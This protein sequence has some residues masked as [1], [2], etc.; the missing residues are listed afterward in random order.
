[1]C[2]W[3]IGEMCDMNGGDERV[4]R[5]F[6]FLGRFSIS[7]ALKHGSCGCWR[8]V[9]SV[10]MRGARARGRGGWLGWLW[11]DDR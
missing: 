1:M 5:V 6:F 10:L 4:C 9:S 7:A 3:I 11:L 8:N 2:D